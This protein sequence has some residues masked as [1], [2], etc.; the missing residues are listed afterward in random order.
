VQLGD[1]VDNFTFTD[2]VDIVKA[3]AGDDNIR[4]GKGNDM[5]FG[6]DGS[7]KLYGGD[8]ADVLSGDNGFDSLY[9]DNGDDTLIGGNGDDILNGG[10]GCDAYVFAKGDGQDIINDYGLKTDIDKIILKDVLLEDVILQKA[11]YNLI[12][13][14]T[15]FDAITVKDYFYSSNYQVE[16]LQIEDETLEITQ[17]LNLF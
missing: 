8:G 17:L 10:N 7:D 1:K 6:E 14:Y 13:N 12:I 2:N 4:L 5:A 11:G 9:G 15:D 3:G 16:L